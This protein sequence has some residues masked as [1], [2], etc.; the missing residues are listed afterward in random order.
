MKN[1]LHI[2]VAATVAT[3]SL[4]SFAKGPEFKAEPINKEVG[5]KDRVATP[6]FV[7]GLGSD[8]VSANVQALVGNGHP[9]A[10]S[11]LAKAVKA[12]DPNADVITGVNG[13]ASANA[14]VRNDIIKKLDSGLALNIVAASLKGSSAPEKAA[15]EV[16]QCG[17]SAETLHAFEAGIDNSKVAAFE[18]AEEAS[19]RVIPGGAWSNGSCALQVSNTTETGGS[20]TY[21]KNAREALMDLIIGEEPCGFTQACATKVFAQQKH[22][23]PA[24]AAAAIAKFGNNC[25][26]HRYASAH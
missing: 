14:A 9:T 11:A 18:R 16:N 20:S 17:D 24:R 5:V 8:D 10:V 26:I 22:I 2:A 1:F 6:D 12:K 13:L 7:K 21:D 15:N 23:D 19:K 4:A 3:I 25:R